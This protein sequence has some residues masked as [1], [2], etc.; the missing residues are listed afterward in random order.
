MKD[1][2]KYFNPTSRTGPDGYINYKMSGGG[3]GGSGG[4]SG[5]GVFGW[6]LII[7]FVLAGVL[8]LFR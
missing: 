1:G 7:L 4:E 8:K 5:C 2:I 3:Q 6:G